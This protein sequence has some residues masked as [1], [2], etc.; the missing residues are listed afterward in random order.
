MTIDQRNIACII[1]E[2][3]W[4]GDLLK[5]R[6]V[7]ADTAV[8]RDMKGL[9]EQGSK[10]AFSLRAQGNVHTDPVSKAQVVDEGIQ[11]CTWDWVV[12]PSH[13]KAYLQSVCEAT[14][15][16]M[17]KKYGKD[18]VAL[19]EASNIFDNGSLISMDEEIV[20]NE[21][22]Y[23]KKYN[24]GLKKLSEM[25]IPSNY[26][27]V[28]SMNENETIINAGDGYRKTVL[29]EDYLVKDI[30]KKLLE[31]SDLESKEE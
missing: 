3:W 18:T 10:V 17:Y 19:C 22:N 13:D 7:T 15:Y 9:I 1:E 31:M 11:I 16:A 25:Y 2:M 29:T 26:D 5:A 21:K 28:V 23:I 24:T 27:A 4:E 20:Y 12:N 6:C 14:A 30:R 8:G